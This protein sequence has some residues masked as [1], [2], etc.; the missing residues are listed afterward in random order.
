[1][2]LKRQIFSG[3]KWSGIGTLSLAVIA[4]LKVSILARLL[5][6]EEFGLMALV[7]FV[8]GFMSVFNEMGLS[9][10]ILHKSEISE[11]EYSTLFWFNLLVGFVV[12]GLL[13]LVTP[14]IALFYEEN[15]LN[16]LIPLV[17]VNLIISSLGQIFRTREQKLL[18]FRHVA[19][20]DIFSAILSLGFAVYLASNGYGIYS[21]IYSY[22]LQYTISNICVFILG[23]IKYGLQF[24]FKISETIPFVK[25]GGYQVGSQ[26]INYFNRDLDIL[27]IGKFFPAEALGVYSLAKQL[28][29]RPMQILNPIVIKVASPTLALLQNSREQLQKG[30]LK[31]I[32]LVATVNIPVY[33]ILF[34][35]SPF[36]VQLFYGSGFGEAI[37]LVRILSIF[38]LI[39]AI[40]SPV[41]SLVVATGRTDLEFIWNIATLV[42]TPICIMIGA[43]FSLLGAAIGMTVSTILLFVPGWRFL[44]FRMTQVSFKNYLEAL[45]ILNVD[46]IKKFLK[47]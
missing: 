12:Y 26:V 24:H 36:F 7:T 23:L 20:I 27:I 18:Q 25:V 14:L 44:V 5:E 4:I 19:L 2:S 3:A 45:F 9:A 10:G 21:L 11:K 43:K 34:I 47:K 32:N 46:Y 16:F 30:Y 37:L 29:M 22:L 8:M 31:L 15:I 40:S 33:I 39:R 28:V 1:M 13:L 38:M 6:K 17:G 41:G 35:F 42:I